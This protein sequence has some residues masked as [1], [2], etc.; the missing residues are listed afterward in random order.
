M[1]K[2]ATCSILANA[3][4]LK[5]A[6]VCL[7]PIASLEPPLRRGALHFGMINSMKNDKYKKARGGWSRILN[8]KCESCTHHVC[9]YQKDGPGPLKRMYFDRI[10]GLSVTNNKLV[11]PKCKE[12]LGTEIIYKKENRYAYRLYVGSITKTITKAKSK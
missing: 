12:I 6:P 1:D 7:W 2:R 4:S 10:I 8:I 9:F 3:S 5:G 11:C